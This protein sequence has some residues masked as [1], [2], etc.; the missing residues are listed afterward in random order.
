MGYMHRC[1]SITLTAIN[2]VSGHI[3]SLINMHFLSLFPETGLP[4]MLM[5]RRQYESW[6]RLC[7]LIWQQENAVFLHNGSSR[8]FLR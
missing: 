4:P 8:M 7:L 3:V 6:K 2:V 5:A 1:S